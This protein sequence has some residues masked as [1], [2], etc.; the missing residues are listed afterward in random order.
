MMTN[1]V[2]FNGRLFGLS[3]ANNGAVFTLCKGQSKQRAHWLSGVKMAE[4]PQF[5]EDYGREDDVKVGSEKAF[6]VVFA[7][8]FLV[9]A[10]FP[11]ISGGPV[12]LWALVVV[13]GFL[14][15]GYFIPAALRPFN[16]VWFKFGLL[17]HKIV[18]PLTMGMLFYL[19]VTPI[20]YLMRLF[21]K[22]PLRLKMDPNA[23]TYWIERDPP[24]P[25]PESMKQQF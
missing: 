22:D 19:S 14:I 9:V 6:G 7:V 11:L 17:L 3:S 23:A 12:R 25:E 5:H 2:D 4:K 16:K 10:L 20:A 24:G 18:S 1:R 15:C 8:V 21:G 13:A